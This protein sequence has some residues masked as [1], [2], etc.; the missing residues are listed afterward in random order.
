M[1]SRQT[2]PP[3]SSPMISRMNGVRGRDCAA[4]WGR[5]CAAG[6]V[7]GAP[8]GAGPSADPGRAPG[9]S[10]SL[11]RPAGLSAGLVRPPARSA[12]P[13]RPAVRSASVRPAVRSADPGRAAGL[14]RPAGGSADPGRRAGRSASPVPSA[15]RSSAPARPADR[16]RCGSPGSRWPG[17]ARRGCPGLERC[18]RPGSR[19]GDPARSPIN[20]VAM[21]VPS[22]SAPRDPFGSRSCRDPLDRPQP[23]RRRARVRGDL[24]GR[25]PHRAPGQL[26]EPRAA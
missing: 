22:L 4:D 19:D 10:A 1:S 18:V 21:S 8:D 12:S 20:P 25:R 26:P 2:R 7:M 14:V 17:P 9:R 6:P 11:E 3:P 16:G 23:G 15:V 13:G 24:L 5:D